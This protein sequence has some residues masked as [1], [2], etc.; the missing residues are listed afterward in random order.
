MK[1]Q[2][3]HLLRLPALATFSLLA[4]LLALVSGAFST[5]F[6]DV[7][8]LLLN[9]G[10]PELKTF[11]YLI[12]HIRIPRILGAGVVGA[13]LAIAGAAIQGLFRNPL[14]DPG[15]IGVNS[16]AMLC[17]ILAIFFLKPLMVILGPWSEYFILIGAAFIGGVM[18]TMLVYRLAT[19]EGH[20]SVA[21]MLLAGIAIAALAGAVSG[22]FI[23]L[24]NDQQ[25]RSITF[26]TM[27]SLS[28]ISWVQLGI[29]GPI[30]LFAIWRLLPSAI[31]LNAIMLGEKE[32]KYMGIEV[33]KVKSQIIYLSA[34]LV[35]AC[36]SMSGMIS[37]VGLVIP[38]FLRL[39]FSYS[40]KYLLP[41]SAI[42]GA[43][44]LIAMDTIARTIISPAE[45]PIG[46]LTALIG[47]PF[48][49][50]LLIRSKKARLL[51]D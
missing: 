12:V 25:L 6:R 33:E 14:A 8:D 34:L 40:Y 27:G 2:L 7:F 19:S 18:T 43:G 22:L 29:G 24:S 5:S 41:A 11:Q 28:G 10:D 4:A 35:G 21:T 51:Y 50:W 16:G 3:Q 15:L 45:L 44:F 47:A 42:L 30:I 32:A 26:W 46:I 38:H 36:I 20:T 48:F 13:G 9:W 23:Y 17:A 31:A 37:F 1:S 39:G 49:L